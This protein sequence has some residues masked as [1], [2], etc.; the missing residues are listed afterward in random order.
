MRFPS[1]LPIPDQGTT[2]LDV[3]FI[4]PI[5]VSPIFI[6]SM[7]GTGLVIEIAG[8]ESQTSDFLNTIKFPD[9]WT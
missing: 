6:P 3:V 9:L 1:A 8:P 2:I 7:A 5:V 4:S